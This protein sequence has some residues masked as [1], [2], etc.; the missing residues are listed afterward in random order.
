MQ[1]CAIDIDHITFRSERSGKRRGMVMR[2]VSTFLKIRMKPSH[3]F[4]WCPKV[5]VPAG[6][7]DV[8]RRLEM[9]R[10]KIGASAVSETEKPI[11]TGRQCEKVAAV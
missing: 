2:S 10:K 3:F 8:E 5:S 7:D 6:I 4:Q 9:M 11:D 1:T